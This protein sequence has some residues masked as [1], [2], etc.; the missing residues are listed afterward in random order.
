MNLL[1]KWQAHRPQEDLLPF[2]KNSILIQKF[3]GK[4]LLH[5]IRQLQNN[6]N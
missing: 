2:G 6:Q 1:L 3:P 4:F 5:L